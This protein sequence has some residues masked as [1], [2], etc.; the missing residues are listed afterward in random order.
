MLCNTT[1]A[2]TRCPPVSSLLAFAEMT[3]ATMKAI[4]IDEKAGRKSTAC[5]VIL[6]IG[7]LY[8]Q[9]KRYGH[10]DHPKYAHEHID[11]IHIDILA[12][13]QPREYGGEQRSQQRGHARHTHRKSQVALGEIGDHIGR[14]T[15]RATAHQHYSESQRVVEHERPSQ[16]PCQRRHD[17]ELCQAADDDILRSAEYHLEVAGIERQSHTKHH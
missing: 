1:T 7:P 10:D 3:I 5:A 11:Y 15:A 17:K 13:Q 16:Q 6:G 2:I 8:Y 9:S 12:C 14:R 4:A